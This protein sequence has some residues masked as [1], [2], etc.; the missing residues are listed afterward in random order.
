MTGQILF[1]LIVVL[2]IFVVGFLSFIIKMYRKVSQGTALV[3]NGAGGAKVTFS[4]ML[5]VP[6]LHRAELM[7]ISLKRIEIER[8]GKDGLICADNIRAD[9]K[10]AFFV[11][12]NKTVDDVLKVAQSVGC[13]R[14]SD[15]KALI[16][17]FDAKFSEALKTVGKQFDF[18]DLYNS[19]ERFKSEILQIIGTDLNGYI[20]DDA[21]IDYLEQTPLEYLIADNILDVYGIR[22]ITEI[23]SSQK[24]E[25]NLI[26]RDKEKTITKQDVE[27]KEAILVLNRQLAESEEK[28]KR[29]IAA[30]KAR[31]G[32]SAKKIIQEE[33]WK[34]E[35]ARIQ[36]EEE[37]QVAEENKNRQIIVAAKNKEKTEAIETERLEKD[38][39]L[40]AT[41]RERV[42]TL[43]QIEKER[44]IEEER[45]NIQE[46]IRERVIVEKAVVQEEEKIKDTKAFAAADREKQVAITNAKML[47][48]EAKIQEVV[49]A[50]AAME[51]AKHSAE[52]QVIEAEADQVAADKKADAM[53]T[54][55]EARVK[56]EA[57][58]GIS[59][60][61]VMEAK[62]EAVE[63]QGTA[64]ANVME[65][66]ALAEARGLEAKAIAIE[67][68]G[69]AEANV[70]SQKYHAEAGGIEEKADSMKK[71]DAVGKEHE[72]FKLRLDL[73]KEIKLAEINIR[74]DIA[75]AQAEIIQEGL[76]AANIDIVG[77]ESMFIDKMVNS[78]TQSKSIDRLVETSQVLTDVK[79]TF[80]KGSP[81][82]F[83]NNL[84]NFVKM[85]GMTSTDLKNLTI[86]A[87]VAKLMSMTTDD[88]SKYMLSLIED[89]VATHSLGDK[90]AEMIYE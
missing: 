42:V 47:T 86:S 1:F 58:L 48:E 6:V 70:M 77:G 59:E 14:A 88:N 18:V 57:V 85:F 2:I 33:H 60:V 22:K 24:I 75:N 50:E 44:T 20:L 72:E 63:K 31:E 90:P 5:V 52:Q 40:E 56:E 51:A 34:A 32:A 30:I 15:H 84:R 16:E 35:Q 65:K 62:A 71:F 27:A 7:E 49:Q 55:A 36:T 73:E 68:Q 29:E 82:E 43:A 4:G 87:L 10:V 41:E 3:R 8:M 53:K 89:F 23:T 21:A 54:L 39:A 9:I 66:K 78:I 80:F 46:V 45:K 17:L 76:K 64:E 12:V 83:K 74:K 61:Q 38:R 69:T 13:E 25:S 67:K 81:R 37:V 19:R 26:D 11:R 28:Q 79:D